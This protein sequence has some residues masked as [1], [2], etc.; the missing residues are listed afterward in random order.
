V[1]VVDTAFDKDTAGTHGL[2]ILGDEGTLLGRGWRRD[3]SKKAKGK[4]QK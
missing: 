4:R 1:R 2:G 3:Q